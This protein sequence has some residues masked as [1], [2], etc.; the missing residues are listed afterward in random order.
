MQISLLILS[1]TATTFAMPGPNPNPE[2][3][4]AV[5]PVAKVSSHF[6][7]SLKRTKIP[8]QP[9]H[10]PIHLRI[11]A[12]H[13]IQKETKNQANPAPLLPVPQLVARQ[14]QVIGGGAAGTL[15]GAEG[16]L[17]G[18]INGPTGFVQGCIGGAVSGATGTTE[19]FPVAT[20]PAATDVSGWCGLFCFL[21]LSLFFKENFV[22]AEV[23]GG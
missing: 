16:T 19:C 9:Y 22:P 14:D 5:T 12:R 10:P 2:A 8:H 4:A 13:E 23:L 6:T 21:S 11:Q 15:G 20:A 3:K 1:L 18:A 17:G 7:F